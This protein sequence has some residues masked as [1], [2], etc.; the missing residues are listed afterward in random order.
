LLHGQLV[1][2]A[3]RRLQEGK[4]G[5]HDHEAM[6]GVSGARQHEL[7]QTPWRTKLT[8]KAAWADAASY[9]MADI[10]MLRRELV[11]GYAVAG[12]L[13]VMVPMRA[14]NDVFLTGHGF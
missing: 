6:V 7:E 13:A 1:D 10:T 9:T 11:I 8:S 2:Q 5:G 14:W 12:L 4:V 3:R